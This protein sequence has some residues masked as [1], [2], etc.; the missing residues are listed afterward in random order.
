MSKLDRLNSWVYNEITPYICNRVLEAV[1]GNGNLISHLADKEV[2]V[3]VDNNPLMLDAFEKRH[4]F[5]GKVRAIKASLDDLPKKDL[6]NLKLD[7]VI[8]L[9]TLE[10]IKEDIEVLKNFNSILTK[11]HLIRLVQAF[12]KLYCPQDKAA[13]HY[14]RYQLKEISEKVESC[15]FEIQKKMYFNLFGILGWIVNGKILKKERLS[16]KLLSL[17]NSFLPFFNFLEKLVGPPFG[18]SIILICRKAS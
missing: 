10:H 13:G 17:F 8:C 6:L 7:T 12:R 4:G 16:N 3:A 14:R 1:C 11:G 5:N 9:N 2:V 15:G 18:L